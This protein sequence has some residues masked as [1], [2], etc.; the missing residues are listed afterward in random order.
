MTQNQNKESIETDKI[1]EILNLKKDFKMIIMNIFKNF[2]GK[3]KY[4][5]ELEGISVEKWKF[6]T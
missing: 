2:V 5:K 3:D 4:N 1:I 6:L